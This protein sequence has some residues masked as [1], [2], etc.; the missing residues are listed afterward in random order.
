LVKT[1]VSIEI[2]ILDIVNI[3]LTNDTSKV[4]S[5]VPFQ[6]QL[7]HGIVII[8]AEVSQLAKLPFFNDAY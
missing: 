3:K 5:I 8:N 1:L 7:I 2:N 6:Y 4:V